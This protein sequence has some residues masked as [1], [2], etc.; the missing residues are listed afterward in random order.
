MKALDSPFR[1]L[2]GPE[3]N[4]FFLGEST[5]CLAPGLHQSPGDQ[6]EEDHHLLRVR[7]PEAPSGVDRGE[8]PVVSR[9]PGRRWRVERSSE[10]FC[11]T[12]NEPG[13]TKKNQQKKQTF[14]KRTICRA[15]FLGVAPSEWLACRSSAKAMA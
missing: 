3:G 13:K 6:R 9:S 4:P 10:K 15:V 5:G 7:R 2:Y 8:G 11:K 12:F 1:I 14:P